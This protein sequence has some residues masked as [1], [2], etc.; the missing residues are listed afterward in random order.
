MYRAHLFSKLKIGHRIVDVNVIEFQYKIY[1]FLT[2]MICNPLPSAR[3]FKAL[4]LIVRV[5]I[6]LIIHE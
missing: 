2:S 6:L 4:C 3:N 1:M 5:F